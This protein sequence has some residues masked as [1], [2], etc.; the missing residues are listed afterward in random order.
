M[1]IGG[2]VLEPSGPGRICVRTDDG[3][4][5][6]MGIPIP[7]D[8]EP[9]EVR[10][11]C[12]IGSYRFPTCPIC[13]DQAVTAEHVPPGSVGG[14]V[15]TWTC[16][17]CNNG[18]GTLVEADLQAWFDQRLVQVGFRHDSVPGLRRAAP[19]R[20]RTTRDGEFALIVVGSD[21][22]LP[23]MLDSG[24]EFSIEF[25]QPDAARYE[26]ALLKHAYLA[27]CLHLR[28]LPTG[29][30]ADAVRA[31]LVA[32]RDSPDRI[33]LPPSPIAGGLRYARSYVAAGSDL[34]LASA[35]WSDGTG[36]LAVLLA[37]ILVRWPIEDES[38]VTKALTL[39]KER[40]ALRD[41]AAAADSESGARGA[42]WEHD[43][44]A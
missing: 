14:V 19:V 10:V 23:G 28:E 15:R 38:V 29:T 3:R 24:G 30:V 44:Q 31:E 7:A 32:V 9:V 6:D 37:G 42:D 25:A 21:P 1:G 8:A 18:L 5:L 40:R 11:L 35:R 17:P 33:K 39:A 22:A 4:V 16:P 26:V 13:G 20:L 2:E 43:H 36:Q 12:E 27:A 41:V 34:F